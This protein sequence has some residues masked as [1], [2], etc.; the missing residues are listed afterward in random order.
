MDIPFD[1]LYLLNPHFPRRMVFCYFCYLYCSLIN[2]HLFLSVV[3]IP[4]R[5]PRSRIDVHRVVFVGKVILSG[6]F[7]GALIWQT[8]KVVHA[9]H[10]GEVLGVNRN[11]LLMVTT[12]E[13]SKFTLRHV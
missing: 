9:L 8:F 1:F 10:G 6:P 13:Y 12:G 2:F 3:G 4:R 7:N 11:V 5:W